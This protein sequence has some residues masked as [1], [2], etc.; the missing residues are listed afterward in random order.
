MKTI[1]KHIFI[2]GAIAIPSL[3]FAQRALSLQDAVQT[4]IDHNPDLKASQLEIQNSTQQQVI[5][6]S[7]LLPVVQASAQVNHYF[8]LNP[9]FGFGET[10][11]SDKIPYGRFGGE[12]QLT[13]VIS[14]VQPIFNPQAFPGIK[15]AGFRT[16][17]SR[18]K[19]DAKRSST[20]LLVK[21]AY[22]QTLLLNE[23]IEL[24]NESV[25]RNE[26]VL[27]DS[28]SLFIQ[29]KGLRVDTLRA[30]T[31]VRNLE[32]VLLKLKFARET[33]KLNLKT[34][35]GIDSLE[36]FQLSD[37]L[38]LVDN[39]AIP[40]EEEVYNAARSRN[41]EYRL[42]ELQN[43]ISEQQVAIASAARMPTV[44]AVGQYQLLSQT[45]NFD[46]GKAY[47]PSASFVGLQLSVPIFNGLSTHAKVKQANLTKTETAL[48][49][50]YAYDQ[51]RASV[52]QVV[53]NSLET[54]VRLETTAAVEE[55]AKLSYSITEYRYKRGVSSRLELADAS[56]ELSTA[57]SNFVEAVYDYL[58]AR[59]ALQHLMGNV[60]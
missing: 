16:E 36:D 7:A 45:N 35:L 5:A 47:Y 23:R 31:A 28:R 27:Q 21:Q 17:E 2:V 51:L 14:A 13:T 24:Q 49:V 12:D 26:R 44:A 34:L 59:I 10:A 46:Y 9:F 57:Q 60:E 20:L 52:H 8:Q 38:F 41:P 42:L 53:A 48:R 33:S 3:T 40:S 6:R 29:G 56:L 11:T 15:Q 19:A 32:P 4:A 58:I 37:S 50:N 1:V 43:H 54:K 18:L 55:T 39:T 25:K 22:L 30:Y